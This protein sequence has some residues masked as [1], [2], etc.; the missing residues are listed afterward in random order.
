VRYVFRLVFLL[1]LS[2]CTAQESVIDFY[3]GLKKSQEEAKTE[4]IAHF[5]KALRHSNN[6]IAT[7]AAAEL[8]GLYSNGT[9]ISL[10]TMALVQQKLNTEAAEKVTA[11]ITGSWIRAL[12]VL[13]REKTA[14]ENAAISGSIAATRARYNEALLFFRMVLNDSPALFFRYPDLLADLGRTF[15]YT[16]TGNEGMELFLKWESVFDDLES[17]D[18]PDLAMYGVIPEG[19]E[20]LVR[21]RLLF[22]AARIARQRGNPHIELF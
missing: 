15:Q 3:E 9:E 7:A 13:G 21:Y 22:Y 18:E 4:A 16:A 19:S 8:M 17:A 5:E 12:E 2:S 1:S 6:Y 11:S 14:A 20:D 10:E